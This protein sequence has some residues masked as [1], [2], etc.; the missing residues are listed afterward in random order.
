MTPDYH[1]ALRIPLR[2]GRLFEATDRAGAPN[3]VIIN[4]AAAKLYFPGESPIGRPVKVNDI[5][6]SV[7]GVVGDVHQTSLEV[8]P[9]TEVYVPMGQLRVLS[10]ELVIRTSG[11]PYD[12]L[13]AVKSAVLQALPDV[14]LRNVR[15]MEEVYRGEWRSAGSTCCCSG[16]SASWGW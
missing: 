6:R 14:P 8:A 11:N 4:E 5:D 7:V 1:K 12:V 3:V 16:C 10:G 13:P 15:T 2:S 9:I